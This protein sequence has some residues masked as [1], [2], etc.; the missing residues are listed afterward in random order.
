M[1]AGILLAANAHV[2]RFQ[3]SYFLHIAFTSTLRFLVYMPYPALETSLFTGRDSWVSI[4]NPEFFLDADLSFIPW[5]QHLPSLLKDNDFDV[6][7][8]CPHYD[9]WMKSLLNRPAVVKVFND[10]DTAIAA[11]KH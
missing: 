8:E 3:V 1:E 9:A 7:K 10:R 6:A 4:I 5:A 11:N 2:S